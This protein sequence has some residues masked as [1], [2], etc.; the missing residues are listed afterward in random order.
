MLRLKRLLL[1]RLQLRRLQLRLNLLHDKLNYKG[2]VFYQEH[3]SFFLMTT[4]RTLAWCWLL[5]ML[6]TCALAQ[7]Q[8]L[9]MQ[10][11][12]YNCENLFDPANNPLKADDEFTPSGLRHWTYSRQ[13]NKLL[14][15]AKVLVAAGEGKP[16]AL[17]GLAEVE[18]DS[19]LYSLTHQTALRDWGFSYVITNSDDERGINVALLYNPADYELLGWEPLAIALPET[20]RKT[21]DVLHAWGRVVGGDTLDV[22][23][24]HLPSRRGG[25]KQSEA[26]RKA[27]HLCIRAALDS[28]SALRQHPH[29][30]VMGDMND[31]PNVRAL[32]RNMSFGDGVHNLM[33]PLDKALKRGRLATGT[34]KFEGEWSLLDQFWVNDGLLPKAQNKLWIDGVKVVCFPFMLTEDTSYLGH[35]P[36]RTFYGYTYEAGYSDHLPIAATMHV[37]F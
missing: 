6:C 14:N 18:N 24:C 20:N 26:Y 17:V 1:R 12:F 8:E 23:V 25:A 35:R 32:K 13:Y 16:L 4:M 22:M 3:S 11:V 19:C 29:L 33:A 31:G 27:A 15:V 5:A 34:H 7:Q 10:L 9:E 21:R 37:R 36:L 30:V 2:G 28:V